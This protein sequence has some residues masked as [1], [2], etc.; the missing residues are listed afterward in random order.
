MFSTFP[1]GWPGRG[2]LL[3][4]SAAGV[5]LLV[6][7]SSGGLSTT[8]GTVSWLNVTALAASGLVV[9]GLW[10][11]L[12]AAALALTEVWFAIGTGELDSEHTMRAAIGLGLLMLGP[13]SW[14][15]DARRYGRKRID[16]GP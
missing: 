10:T 3:L 8:N 7:C 11:P 12:A 1:N 4:R 5:P 14:S 16:L 2:L 15:I 13:G 6:L 9:A